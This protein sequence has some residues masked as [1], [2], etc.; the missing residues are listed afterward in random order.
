[1][2]KKKKKE[3]NLENWTIFRVQ[4]TPHRLIFTP[5]WRKRAVAVERHGTKERM[6]QDGREL[7][8]G[9]GAARLRVPHR[10]GWLCKQD[11]RKVDRIARSRV[12]IIYLPAGPGGRVYP[13]PNTYPPAQQ[14]PPRRNLHR[15]HDADV[16]R[17]YLHPWW[18]RGPPRLMKI[19][20]EPRNSRAPSRGK[21]RK[22]RRSFE[23]KMFL[24]Y[25][26]FTCGAKGGPPGSDAAS[27]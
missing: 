9:T 2:K 23:E 12:T 26:G 27:S 14:R 24:S 18:E 16:L 5:P 13:E 1:M 3:N 22:P 10:Y 8:S 17:A 19:G 25:L 11:G 7:W 15:H 6:N 20:S 4:S 21:A